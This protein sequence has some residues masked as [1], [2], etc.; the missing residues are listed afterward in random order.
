MQ[1][2]SLHRTMATAL[3]TTASDSIVPP[4]VGRVLLAICWLT[5]AYGTFEA[6]R[7][8]SGIRGVGAWIAALLLLLTFT[9]AVE[10]P[11]AIW[12]LRVS[13]LAAVGLEICAPGNGAFVAVI[14]VIAVAGIRMEAGASRPVAAVA[15][16]GFLAAG[17]LG[18]RPVP[19]AQLVSVALAL[20]FTYVGATATRRLRTE[21]R[22]TQELLEEVVAGRDAVI[23]A[24]AL[25]ER[26]H[27]AREMHDVLA[28]TL[29]ALSIQLEGARMLAEQRAADPAVAEAVERASRLA[30]QGLGEARRAVGSLRGEAL[31]G[32]DLLPQLAQEFELDTGVPCRLTIAGETTGLSPDARLA[33]YRIAQESLSNVRKHAAASQVTIALRSDPDG[34]E[35]TVENDGERRDDPLAG[36]GFGVNGMRERAALLHGRLE[37]GPTAGGYRVQAWIPTNQSAS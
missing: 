8:P 29:S 25:D 30:R 18:S 26:A 14:A 13:A 32:P 15:G 1:A 35:L 27:L 23:R 28:H 33:L 37:A 17:A 21:Q 7:H 10:R 20:F 2:G 16:V 31:P 4:R 5:V 9:L 3:R 11:G 22:R 19:P 36:G 12:I 6:D 34:V 24:A